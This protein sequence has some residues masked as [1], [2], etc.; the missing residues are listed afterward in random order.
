MGKW[1][2]DG[3]QLQLPTAYLGEFVPD[4]A[5]GM[6]QGGATHELSFGRDRGAGATLSSYHS[7]IVQWVA[8]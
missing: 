8:Q 5:V 7:R 6:V 3:R 2:R 1:R 4:Q